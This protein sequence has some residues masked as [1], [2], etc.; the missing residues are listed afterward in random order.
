MKISLF[1]SFIFLL[2]TTYLISCSETEWE[3]NYHTHWHKEKKENWVYHAHGHSHF[4]EEGNIRLHLLRHGTKKDGYVIRKGHVWL[5]HEYVNEKQEYEEYL[6]W[7]KN[8]LED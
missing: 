4:I 7:A 3:R 6:E 1:F 8:N 5:K 2:L